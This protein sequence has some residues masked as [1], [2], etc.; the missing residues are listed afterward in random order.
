[1]RK[2]VKKIT[3]DFE[4]VDIFNETLSGNVTVDNPFTRNV[5]QEI[6]WKLCATYGIRETQI[7]TIR[8]IHCE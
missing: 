2:I 7:I 8:N 1:M 5:L 4:I 3:A 6:K